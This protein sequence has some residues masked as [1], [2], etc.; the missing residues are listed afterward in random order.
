M[1]GLHQ[2]LPDDI[3][4][5]SFPRSGNNWTRYILAYLRSRS[6]SPLDARSIN[7]LA[8]DIYQRL[9]IV[10]SQRTNRLIKIHAPVLDDCPRVIAVH[11]DPREALV[12]Y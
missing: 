8:P 6:S 1:Y 5:A 11:R 12:S 4:I 3:Y 9:E 10:N 2:I 7:L